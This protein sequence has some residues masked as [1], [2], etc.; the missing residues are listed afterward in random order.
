MSTQASVPDAPSQ[1]SSSRRE[2]VLDSAIL[3]FARF[4]YRKTSMD[5][6][7]RAAGISRPGLYFLFISKEELFR[8]AVTRVL[9]SDLTAIEVTLADRSRP[10]H[11]RLLE[12]F[13]R[14]AGRYIGPLSAD[15]AVVIDDNPML[16][17]TIV[18]D[19]PRRFAELIAN[20]IVA[21]SISTAAR[22]A[23]STAPTAVA[24]T[25]ISVSIG[26]KYQVD[27]RETYLERLALAIDLLIT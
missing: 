17:G 15:I 20:T 14:W 1:D 19:A 22:R 26:L 23:P 4:G 3:T 13:D 7:A 24:Q 2:S 6:I 11:D 21:E 5:E 25:L 12:G 8:A 10:L 16:L 9:T 18:H 27:S